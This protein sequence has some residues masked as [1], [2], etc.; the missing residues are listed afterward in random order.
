MRLGQGLWQH[1]KVEQELPGLKISDYKVFGN[2]FTDVD[3]REEL[4][5]HSLTEYGKIAGRDRLCSRF[6]ILAVNSTVSPFITDC[7]FAQARKMS[8]GSTDAFGIFPSRNFMLAEYI[9]AELVRKVSNAVITLH[10]DNDEIIVMAVRVP[11]FE[12]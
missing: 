9:Q 5:R 12:I 8:R 1:K 2:D 6:I 4:C 10:F 7:P 11:D 3:L